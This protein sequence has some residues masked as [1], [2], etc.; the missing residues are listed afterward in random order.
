MAPPDAYEGRLETMKKRSVEQE[1]RPTTNERI[2]P[3]NAAFERIYR[4]Y[5]SDLAK[6]FREAQL[7]VTAKAAEK[8]ADKSEA[9]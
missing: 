6:F 9:P 3:E 4:R 8:C 2:D 7:A 1:S 5:G